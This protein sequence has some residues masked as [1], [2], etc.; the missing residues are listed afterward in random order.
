MTLN[1]YTE[2]QRVALLATECTYVIMGEEV[3]EQGTPHLQGFLRFKTEKS[4]KQMKKISP[5]AHWENQ[6][7]TSEEAST[8]CKKEG[9]FVEV[10]TLPMSQK[11]KGECNIERWEEAREA[12]KE[13][14]FEDVP[15]D[16]YMRNLN[17]C[18]KIYAMSQNVPTALSGEL[19]NEWIWGPAGSGKSSL[20]V[21]EN[22][23][24]YLKGLNKW[25]D[26][27]VAQEAVIVDDMDPFHKSLAQE[28]KQWGH[29]HP[30]PAETKGGSMCIRPKK[31]IVTSN[32]RIDDVWEE[33]NTRAAIHR[34]F[35][36]IYVPSGIA[37]E[38]DRVTTF[39]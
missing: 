19:T 9:H 10:G 5:G 28:F 37:I 38:N 34:R 3:G 17:A 23:G 18:H 15:A 24:A 22:P 31:I 30:F 14:R 12:C 25:W 39:L 2:E 7:G 29:H 8:Y 11:R 6:K 33:E 1:N 27:Y 35:K 20:A 16:I 13:G 4:L 21:R 32:Y 36:E 26:G